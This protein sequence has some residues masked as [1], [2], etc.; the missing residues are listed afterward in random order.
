MFWQTEEWKNYLL[1]D[2]TGYID[3]SMR[4]NGKFVPLLQLGNEF[5]SPGFEDN[6]FNLRVIED[7]ALLYEIKRI[8]V[9]S[10]IKSYL[11]IPSLTCIADP[12][13]VKPT[14]GHKS[15]IAK[16]E[17]YL[18]H[19]SIT[20]LSDVNRFRRDYFEIAGKQTRPNMTFFY[21]WKWIDMGYGTLL[22]ATFQ[23]ETAGYL[24]ILHYGDYAYYF[25]SC[26]FDDYKQYNVSHYLQSKAFEI[27]REKNIHTY[28]MGEQCYNSFLLQPS[29]K[30]MNISKFKRGFGGEIVY[31]PRSE[32]FFDAEYMKQ[33]YENRIIKYT[34]AWREN[35]NHISK[36]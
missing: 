5:Y 22:R 1:N 29:E 23:S 8:Q 32:Y 18:E 36:A 33:T 31:K 24:Y 11:Q 3:R 34:E 2:G 15:A 26:V 25:M 7:Q 20:R 6:K 12:F 14:K 27:L 21:L 10:L 28:E 16:A 17:K 30:E 4:I 35:I 13:A 19:E 9:D